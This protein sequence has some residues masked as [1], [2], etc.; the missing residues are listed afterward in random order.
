MLQ[1]VLSAKKT[2]EFFDEKT[3]RFIEGRASVQETEVKLEHSLLSISKWEAKWKKP[4]LSDH[5]EKTQEMAVD[6]VR[7]MCLDPRY[8]PA[9]E[10]ANAKELEKIGAYIEDTMTATSISNKGKSGRQII[11][12]ELIYGWMTQFGIPF[13]CEKWHLN[14]LLMLIGVCGELNGKPKKGGKQDISRKYADINRARLSAS[15]LKG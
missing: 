10:R 2:E 14:R 3:C 11:T 12:S 6:Y 5:Y 7:C 15:G 13:S 9:I 8:I 4:Y 1:L